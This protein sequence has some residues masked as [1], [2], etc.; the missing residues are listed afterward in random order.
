MFQEHHARVFRAAYRVTGN[1]SDA[2]DVLQNVFLRLVR[3][4]QNSE[5]VDNLESYLYRAAINTSLDLLRARKLRP[6]VALEDVPRG[7]DAFAG[8]DAVGS[9][10]LQS[11]LRDALAR[12]NPRHAEMFVLRY[13]EGYDNREIAE[14]LHT[15][16]AVI[17]VTLHRTRGSLQ[18]DYLAFQ[19]GNHA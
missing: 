11:W 5:A 8:A 2:E 1:A 3:R 7:E 12:L 13:I 4:E 18:K 19:R 17:A 15:S 10:E 14:M 9:M 6:A 16:Q